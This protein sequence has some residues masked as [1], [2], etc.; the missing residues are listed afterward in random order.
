MSS[1]YTLSTDG[2]LNLTH[3]QLVSTTVLVNMYSVRVM[4]SFGEEQ[5]V[6]DAGSHTKKWGI[7]TTWDGV[8]RQ[9]LHLKVQRV[10]LYIESPVAYENLERYTALWQQQHH[11][12]YIYMLQPNNAT[13]PISRL[14]GQ[15][16]SQLA[17]FET[18]GLIHDS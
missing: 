10:L 5:C 15:F 1:S 4:H 14:A 8:K 6:I 18:G 9:S 16:R 3:P 7:T 13:Q 11:T 2:H 17:G 12:H